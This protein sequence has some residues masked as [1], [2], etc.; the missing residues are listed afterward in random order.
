MNEEKSNPRNEL[1][2]ALFF[3]IAMNGATF[4]IMTLGSISTEL[5]YAI[6]PILIAATFL[7]AYK[8]KDHAS[9]FKHMVLR[10]Y[11]EARKF[12][13]AIMFFLLL[14]LVGSLVLRVFH[15][16]AHMSASSFLLLLIWI[17]LSTQRRR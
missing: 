17:E 10:R 5:A 13:R 7:V 12:F 3:F 14:F 16:I 11:V 9:R 6:P 4:L 2:D 1:L 8:Y 15:V